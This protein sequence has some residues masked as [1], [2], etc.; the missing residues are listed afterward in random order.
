MPGKRNLLAAVHHDFPIRQVRRHAFALLPSPADCTIVACFFASAAACWPL[1]L[2]PSFPPPHFSS[3]SISPSPTASES[4]TRHDQPRLPFT[5]SASY[6][7]VPIL[8][9]DARSCQLAKNNRS[10]C[11]PSGVLPE[12]AYHLLPKAKAFGEELIELLSSSC[13][14]GPP[15][16]LKKKNSAR[17]AAKRMVFPG[18]HQSQASGPGVKKIWRV[19]PWR[20]SRS[21]VSPFWS[22]ECKAFVED[23]DEESKKWVKESDPDDSEFD[24]MYDPDAQKEIRQTIVDI[25]KDLLESIA[26]VKLHITKIEEALD[27]F[28][29]KSEELAARLTALDENTG[30]IL[31]E[32]LGSIK[33]LQADINQNIKAI[34]KDQNAID[35]DEFAMSSSS[36]FQSMANCRS[37]IV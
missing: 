3:L 31:D 13:P 14:V 29:N 12:K 30:A 25:T 26:P 18:S 11:G 27:A 17:I 16:W 35:S 8:V 2:S 6:Q 15:S 5:T 21:D 37:Q 32:D 10:H 9:L 19:K 34:D 24:N 22:D 23:D 4:H 28:D 33:E 7:P 1:S 36:A 20:W